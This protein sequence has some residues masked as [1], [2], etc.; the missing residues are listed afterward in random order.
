[1]TRRWRVGATVALATVVLASC[2]SG[3]S[4]SMLDTHAGEARHIA[5]VWW[6]MFGIAAGV[7]LIVATLI[8]WALLRGRR[9]AART[10]RLNENAFIVVGGV[11]VPV[12]I[13]A[14]LAVVTVTTTKSVRADKP[15]AL[16]VEVVG[17]RW[18]WEV[19]Y[20][21]TKVVTANEVHVPTGRPLDIQ[22][23]SDN[24]IHSFWVPQ[25]AGKVDMIPGQHNHLRVTVDDPGTYLGEC[26]E[27]CAV[28]HAHMRFVVIADPPAEFDRWMTRREQ[29][30]TNPVSDA[31]AR[32]Q[33]VFQR[34]SCA[35][36]HTI[37]GTAATG[38]I[39]PDLTDFGSRKWIAAATLRNTRANLAAW[40]A[41][42]QTIK[43]GNL[44]PPM[45]LSPGDLDAVVAYLESL[46]S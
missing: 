30:A 6:L 17:K 8:F 32:G 21:G 18:W 35:G 3:D 1:V 38:V 44:M 15:G 31:A 45:S 13:L 28:G 40:I 7:Y 41:N 24:V 9:R 12:V 22:L 25:L 42:S 5:G 23:D 33:A 14:L 27:F 46:G 16:R 43:P 36:C 34:E 26:A 4:P 11:V 20:P 10:S 19:R 29:A 37:R 39:G 2:G